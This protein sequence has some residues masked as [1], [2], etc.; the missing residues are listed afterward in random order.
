MKISQQPDPLYKKRPYKLWRSESGSLPSSGVLSRSVKTSTVKESN[1]SVWMCV[2]FLRLCVYFRSLSSR[3]WQF[4]RVNLSL[5]GHFGS[6][7]CNFESLPSHLESFP[8]HFWFSFQLFWVF[9][10]DS[11][12]LSSH[13]ASLS[14]LFGISFFFFL[15]F[16]ACLSS[17]FTFLSTPCYW[18]VCTGFRIEQTLQPA[19]RQM[20]QLPALSWAPR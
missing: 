9:T 12:S 1:V 4:F 15:S 19:D 13:F 10:S 8:S 20:K 18:S 3:F 11:A 16:W 5:C 14:S 2:V 7:C 17:C 6:L